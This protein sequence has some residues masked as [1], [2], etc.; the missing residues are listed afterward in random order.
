MF[1]E[2]AVLVFLTI[3]ILGP[4]SFAIIRNRR[5]WRKREFR[6]VREERELWSVTP[7]P[8]FHFSQSEIAATFFGV[9]LG[10]AGLMAYRTALRDDMP[11]VFRAFGVGLMTYGGYL[12]TLRHVRKRFRLAR[13]RYVI[14]SLRVIMHEGRKSRWIPIEDV[15]LVLADEHGD[16]SGTMHVYSKEIRTRS[17][18]QGLRIG[19]EALI[20]MENVPDVAG[21]FAR[22][23]QQAELVRIR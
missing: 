21:L 17:L 16:S 23:Q 4:T 14:T 1:D 3:L 18:S 15:M 5:A 9:L 22:I 11:T 8:S 19:P 20:T 2:Y 13:T 10:V 12:L 7:S 6:T